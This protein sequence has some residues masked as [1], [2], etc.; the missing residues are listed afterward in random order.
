[1]HKPLP[2]LVYFVSLLLVHVVYGAVYLGILSSIPEYINWLNKS[3]QIALCLFLM[4][5]YRPFQQEYSFHPLD[6][7]LI[8]G[9]AFLL[10]CN[11]VSLSLLY[12]YLPLDKLLFLN[13]QKLPL[14][15]LLENNTFSIVK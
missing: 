14:E 7:Q 6:A 13:I 8:F 5:R 9:S 12:S 1:M 11:I 10:F 3:V 4:Y 2:Y 15:N